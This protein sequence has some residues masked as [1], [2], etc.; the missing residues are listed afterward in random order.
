MTDIDW[1]KTS[2]INDIDFTAPVLVQSV[3]I[4]TWLVS[5]PALCQ[6]V[7]AAERPQEI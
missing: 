6:Y 3:S 5:G 4:N 2:D 1:K 7:V